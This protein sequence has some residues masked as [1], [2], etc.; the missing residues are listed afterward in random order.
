M[1]KIL[2][3]DTSADITIAFATGYDYAGSTVHVD[4]LGARRSFASVTAGGTVSFNF[5]A[6]ETKAMPLGTFPVHVT[7]VKN[8]LITTIKNGGVKI[9]VT[10]DISE[11]HAGAAIAVDV[12]GGLF[13][14]TDLPAR[15]TDADVVAKLREILRKG[16]A[17]LCA[18]F[19][20]L[21]LFADTNRVQTARKDSIYNDAQVVTNVDLTG[22]VKSTDIPSIVTNTVT[23]QFVQN[24]GISGGNA[25][26]A[27]SKEQ[28]DAL[29]AHKAT[30]WIDYDL[31]RQVYNSGICKRLPT[32]GYSGTENVSIGNI[33]K[34]GR[35]YEITKIT[36]VWNGGNSY[37]ETDRSTATGIAVEEGNNIVIDCII[38][39]I[40]HPK[41]GNVTYIRMGIGVF[42]YIIKEYYD[43]IHSIDKRL[44]DYSGI[45]ESI[46]TINGKS[47]IS[48]NIVIS[49]SD[50]AMYDGSPMTLQQGFTTM[51]QYIVENT[52][53]PDWVKQEN[54]PE[55]MPDHGLV[56]TNGAVK[57]KSGT[58]ITAAQVGAVSTAQFT[59]VSTAANN[60]LAYGQGIYQYMHA[61]TNAWFEGTN[62]NVDVA[63]SLNK[64]KYSP[65]AWENVAYTPCSL[66]LYE[67]R[68]GSRQCVW[69][70]RDWTVYYWN[71]K[72]AQLSNNLATATA[73][74]SNSV[75]NNYMRKGWAKY[76]AVNGVTNPANDTLW[77][78]TSKVSL[79]AGK[80]WEKMIELGG[81][82]YWTLTGNGVTISTNVAQSTFLSIKDF[83]G[84]AC[85]T[86]RKTSSYLV[87]C[88]CGTEITGQ[89]YDGQ[90]R[91]CFTVNTDTCP[92]AEFT[93]VLEDDT[94][95][96]QGATGC[97][98]DYEWT[99]SAGAWV[100]HF[101]L[102]SGIVSN[103]C[104][105]R[106]KVEHEGENV[107]E[108]TVPVKLDGGIVFTQ[109]GTQYKIKPSISGGNVV[110]SVV[111]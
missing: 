45:S 4:F 62:Y 64:V 111:Q 10:D 14:I 95:V 47:I 5:T 70:Q 24:L 106:F 108:H 90:G 30:G 92:I 56:L 17:A 67:I 28:A 109:G 1:T 58:A 49:G 41:S 75:A 96:E 23:T 53:F 48:N 71:F 88:E 26:N 79:M 43:Q 12:K 68:N 97:P 52:T 82:G 18:A 44:I 105:A 6:E 104:F 74:L 42:Q 110:W 2:K 36:Y 15:Y 76:T 65:E 20:C 93:T 37:D 72:S 81:A 7:L 22:F 32:Y 25:T 38:D 98:A 78:D 34:L 61:N 8:G 99:G 21:G 101:K 80:Q 94:F 35:K 39:D 107:V 63:Q 13:G 86:F 84:N 60:A 19:L 69:E 100:C 27:Y 57:T 3:G 55:S 31:K 33:V 40:F 102:K 11:V 85:L 29:L 77:V 73:D 89:L 9:S 54:P 87:Y 50:V 51:Y 91:V 16:G 66:Q 59:P 83:E 46:G 103:A